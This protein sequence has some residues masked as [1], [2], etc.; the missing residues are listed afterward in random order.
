MF[1]APQPADA[2]VVWDVKEKRVR[3]S[4][5][6]TTR[7]PCTSSRTSRSSATRAPRSR[8]PGLLSPGV[9]YHRRHRPRQQSADQ[10]VHRVG[11]RSSSPRSP[12]R[13]R[14]TS[15]PGATLRPHLGQGHRVRHPTRR[16]VSRRQDPGE[17]DSRRPAQL[18]VSWLE[19]YF[20]R[21]PSS[22]LA[23]AL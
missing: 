12:R 1:Q 22:G 18:L 5:P 13:S 6:S 23:P 10:Q 4:R 3:V 15:R 16:G 7:S 9:S 14:Q 11:A 21:R 19:F 8:R 17:P 2:G 20:T